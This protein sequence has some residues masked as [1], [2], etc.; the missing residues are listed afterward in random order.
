MLLLLIMSKTSTTVDSVVNV[1]GGFMLQIICYA[2]MVWMG[3]VSVV[4]V[5][6][7][8]KLMFRVLK[9]GIDKS[10]ELYLDEKG[11]LSHLIGGL[12]LIAVLNDKVVSWLVGFGV[13]G[14]L[15]AAI[16]MICA[17]IFNSFTYTKALIVIGVWILFGMWL[18]M[19]R[20]HLLLILGVHRSIEGRDA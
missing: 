15:L 6:T 8:G 16:Y 1:C 2:C 9:V 5:Y 7:I 13:I 18:Y 10:A 19:I 4:V 17:I 3:L 20:R 11:H 12:L 14:I